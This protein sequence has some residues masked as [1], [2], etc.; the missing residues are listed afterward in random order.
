M[1]KN[2]KLSFRTALTAV[3]LAG[4]AAFITQCGNNKEIYQMV[5]VEKGDIKYTISSTGMLHPKSTVEVGAQISGTFSKIYADYNDVVKKGQLLAKLDKHLVKAIAEEARAAVLRT[6]EQLKYSRVEYKRA[7]TIFENALISES[8]FLKARATY[9]ADSSAYL[10][11][12][13]N[14]DRAITNLEYTEIVSP[15]A[16]TVIERNVEAGQTVAAN[17]QTPTLFVIAEDLAEMEIQA[18]VDESDISYIKEGQKVEFSVLSYP[19]SIFTGEVSQ[20]RMHPRVVQNVVNYIVIINTGNKY[21]L[22]LPGMTATVDFIVK[23]KK[24]VL[25][26]AKSAVSFMP[27]EKMLKSFHKRMKKKMESL[28]DSL[29]E[30]MQPPPPPEGMEGGPGQPPG[31]PS[32]GGR[33]GQP[34][35]NNM[36]P[37][38]LSENKSS[39][40]H[41]KEMQ[42]PLGGGIESRL[43]QQPPA[44]RIQQPG[45]EGKTIQ[46]RPFGEVGSKADSLRRPLRP[47]E[48]QGGPAPSDSTGQP[49]P[50]GQGVKPANLAQV[51]YLDEDGD[52]AMEPVET[53]VSDDSYIE[54]V[55]YR[56]LK[57]GMQV[58]S[59][60]IE[61]S[62]KSRNENTQ[63]QIFGGGPPQQQGGGG[64]PPMGPQ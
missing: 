61:P 12:K 22:L 37:P 24:D 30:M 49:P 63:N 2:R 13:A 52:L 28:P 26:V 29:R 14:L 9:Y 15:I 43:Y 50:P 10:S 18:T 44:E 59:G 53:G 55:R 21:G 42:P 40:E 27:P 45:A 17:F 56:Y 4:M 58:I 47:P 34:G 11:A 36:Q 64:P 20:I 16:G 57:P 32:D 6:R 33:A 38:P 7:K 60:I 5:P 25:R 23:Y 51:W 54:L 1:S 8:D 62:K 39:V 48:F 3:V 19:D 35:L 46:P 41:R 31:Q